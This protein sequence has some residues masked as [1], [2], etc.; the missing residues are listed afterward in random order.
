M[1]INYRPGV[2]E[3][4]RIDYATLRRSTRASSIARTPPLA[5]W[6]LAIAAAT[7]SSCRR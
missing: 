4:L 5:G 3:Q 7:T 1:L 6:A 2:A